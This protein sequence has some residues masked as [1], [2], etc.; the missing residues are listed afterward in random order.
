MIL[1]TSSRL[2][3]SESFVETSTPLLK[4]A[5]R[6]Q[7]FT[8]FRRFTR[9]RSQRLSTENVENL[10]PVPTQKSW[11]QRRGLPGITAP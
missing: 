10:D 8:W 4:S 11:I 5:P 3:P 7:G 6:V 9:F 2:D 1:A